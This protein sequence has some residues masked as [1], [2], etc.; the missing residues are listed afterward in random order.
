MKSKNIDIWKIFSIFTFLSFLLFLVYPVLRL[1]IFSIYT[2]ESGI[3]FEQFSKIFSKPYYS[4]TLLNSLKVS[5]SATFLTMILATPLAYFTSFYEIKGKKLLNII[6]IIASMS[7]PFIGAY[8][9]ILL[10]GRNGIITNFFSNFLNIKIPDIYGFGGIL[11]VFSLQLYPLVFLYTKS[12][13]LNIDSTLMEASENLGCVGLRRFFKVIFPLII[14]QTLASGLLVFMR[15]MSDFGTP[16]LIGEGYR[17]FPVL[18]YNEFV[19]EVGVDKNFASALSVVAVILTTAIFLIQKRL[20]E[21][22]SYASNFLHPVDPKKSVGAKNILMHLYVYILVFLS[23]LPQIYLIYTSFKKT[24]GKIFIDGYSLNSYRMA[25]SRM[26]T[27][28][29]NTIILPII[30]LVIIIIFSLIIS[31]LVVRKKNFM[32]TA[33]DIMSMIP[34]ILPGVVIGIAL[35]QGF[36]NGFNG[37]NFMVLGGSIWIVIISFVIR[38][39]PYTLRTSTAT[40]QSIPIVIEEAAVSLGAS[41]FKTF[42]KITVP[43][44]T[45]GVISGAILSYV[46]LISELST[47]VLLTNIKTR[48]MTVAIYTEVVRG[49]YGIAAA[50]STILTLMTVIALVIFTNYENKKSI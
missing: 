26:G 37:S 1:L 48:T 16:M 41:K 12:A 47:S 46:T 29:R 27:S 3:S 28:I 38:R 4:E 9:W 14:P 22:N 7:A 35:L 43:M 15:C 42:L 2:P 44:M 31:Y 40:L 23:I 45:R 20:S 5:I 49:N 11:L 13:L 33:I 39:M 10:L 34:F 24:S 25:F 17:T 6:I 50:L 32:N 18:I 21:K 30:A 36:G 19:G 8:S